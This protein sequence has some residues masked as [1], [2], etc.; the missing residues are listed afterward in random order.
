MPRTFRS[1]RA[2]LARRSIRGIISVWIVGMVATVLVMA[3]LLWD[4]LSMIY[5]LTLT[6]LIW[7]SVGAFTSLA[8][9]K[10]KRMMRQMHP[11]IP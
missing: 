5:A 2:E 11:R 1:L 6:A 8:M 10:F 7:V 9:S 4:M 3:S